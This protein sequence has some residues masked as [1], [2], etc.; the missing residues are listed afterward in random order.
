MAHQELG[1]WFKMEAEMLLQWDI[2]KRDF[3]EISVLQGS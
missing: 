2:K 3:R 1:Y